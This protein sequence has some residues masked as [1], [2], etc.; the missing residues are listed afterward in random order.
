MSFTDLKSFVARLEERRQLTRV[1]VPVSTYLEMA[2]IADRLVKSGGPAVLFER[3]VDRDGRAL[4]TPVVMNLFGTRERMALALG[5]ESLDE[6]G[7]R[8]R[9]LLD[10]KLGGGLLGLMSN[11]PKLREV[12]ALPPRRVRTAPVQRVVQR[13]DE[14][15]LGR[16]PVLTTWPQDGGPFITLPLVITRDPERGDLNIGM[17]RMQVLDRNSTA[18]HWQRHKTGARHM[19]AAA[20]LGRRLEVAV[21]IGGDPALT[22]AATAPLP[23]VPGLNEYSLTGFLRGRQVEVVKGVTVDLEVPAHAEIVL[24]GYVDPNEDLVVEGPFGDHTGF[25]TLPDEYPRFHVTAVTTSEDPLY[26]ATVVGRPP[27]E[28]AYLIEASERIFLEPARFILPEIVDYHLPPAGIAHNLVNV[29]I[30]KSY[31]GQAFKVANGLLGL[32]QMMLAKVLLVS[33]DPAADPKDHLG[34]WRK[35]LAR[36]VPGRDNQFAKGPMDVLDHSSRAF[37]YGSKLVLDGTRKMAEE[38]GDVSYAPNPERAAGEL[39]VHAEIEDQHQVAGGFWFIT[40]KKKRPGQGRHLAEWAAR[41]GAAKGVR[42][43]AVVDELCNPRDFDDCIWTMLNNI[44]PERDVQIVDDTFAA[45][46]IFAVDATPKLSSEGFARDWPEKLVM[47][48][49]VR[50]KVD[51]L[52]PEMFE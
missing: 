23:P 38:G 47:P 46:P 16:L 19:A 22:Y 48:A 1:A 32:G 14:V 4:N 51:N 21:A 15:D 33:D 39:P 34:F 50:R 49:A 26:P 18:M 11:L 27:M 10:V 35:V 42:L 31:P 41:Q 9:S 12:A 3:P 24:E 40:T 29:V 52:W 28:D 20:R 7:E 43:I 17:Y 5:V 25:Y 30:E 45:A 8:I 36:A 6:V 2:E 44:D 13:G 37:S